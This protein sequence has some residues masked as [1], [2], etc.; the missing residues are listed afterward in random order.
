MYIWCICICVW[1]IRTWVYC[2]IVKQAQV[3]LGLCQIMCVYAYVYIYMMHMYMC[4]IHTYVNMLCGREAGPNVSR[5]IPGMLHM[6]ICMMHMYMYDAY[7][8]VWYIYVHAYV[9]WQCSQSRVLLL[10]CQVCVYMNMYICIHTCISMLY[11]HKTG[12]LL[13]SYMHMHMYIHTCMLRG[14]TRYLCMY[15]YIYTYA[16]MVQDYLLSSYVR[17]V[18]SVCT[19]VDAYACLYLHLKLFTTLT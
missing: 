17:F 8:Y 19:Y 10:L 5:L 14:Y 3:F 7:V 9:V 2:V 6:Y 16:Y 11:S 12:P 1:Y 13:L 4:M 18:Y 15:V